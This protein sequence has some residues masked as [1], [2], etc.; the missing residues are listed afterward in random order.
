MKI[1]MKQVIRDRL[2]I[3]EQIGTLTYL[4]VSITGC[5]LRRADCR[6]MEPQIREH[7]EGWQVDALSM[8]GRATLVRSVLSSTPIYLLAN[9]ILPYSCLRTLEQ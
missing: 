8:M 6:H 2:G 9:T 3:S 7:F 5:R 1:Q 4:D